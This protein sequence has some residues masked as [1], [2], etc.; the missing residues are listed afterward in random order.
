MKPSDQE[1]FASVGKASKPPD[2]QPPTKPRKPKLPDTLT[3]P[4]N[5]SGVGNVWYD[6]SGKRY[7]RLTDKDD[8]IGYSEQE[9]K[10]YLKSEGF[11]S[12]PDKGH[13]ISAADD[14]MN[15]IMHHRRVDFAGSISGYCVDL[16]K[17]CDR[18][19][20]VTSERKLHEPTKGEWKDIKHLLTGLFGEDRH[21]VLAWI[22]SAIE[23]LNAGAPWRP[24]PALAL[25]G[26]SDC[27]K[28]VLQ[29][30][31]TQILGGRACKP[32]GYMTRES[33]YNSTHLG[34][35]HWMIE[36][37]ADKTDFRTRKIFGAMLKN[38]LVNQVHAMRAMYREAISVTPFVRLTITVNDQ[39][40]ALRVLPP[41]EDD[42]ADKIILLKATAVEFPFSLGDGKA[43]AR[44]EKRLHKQ[45]PAFLFDLERY[46]IKEHMRS[47]RYGVR[48]YHHPEL[49]RA[50]HKLSPEATLLGII[51]SSGVW[52]GY[53]QNIVGLSHEIEEEVRTGK[54]KQALDRLLEH[55]S[56]LGLLLSRLAKKFP[57]RVGI[58]SITHHQNRYIVHAP[59]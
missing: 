41:I 32:Y 26:P 57:E 39:P 8:V 53:R 24:G 16:Y 42:T 27:G 52:S 44:Y 15:R 35:E 10:R 23:A 30:L 29:N 9:F 25:A 54:T 49:L 4:K 45:I 6:V 14:L 5:F 31:I 38:V 3:D 36:D 46:E 59:K 48:A 34:C 56:S 7:W 43:Y 1:K 13:T 55:S 20:L 12:T 28:S 22:K 50:L 37:E 51:D 18:R 40:E 2:A 33:E 47:R 17:M 21:W 19:V 58:E 11:A